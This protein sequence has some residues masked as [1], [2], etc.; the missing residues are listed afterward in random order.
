MLWTSGLRSRISAEGGAGIDAHAVPFRLRT[1]TGPS[2]APISTRPF[3]TAAE[4]AAEAPR[5]ASTSGSAAREQR[6]ERRRVRAPR[7][8]RGRNVM[9][10][11]RELGVLV[12]VEEVVDG[13]IAVAARDERRGRAELDQSL[14]KLPSR[15]SG[16]AGQRLRLGQVRRHD[17]REREEP[18]DQRLDGVVLQQLRARARDQDR[19][20][21]ERDGVPLEELRDRLDDRAREEHPGLRGVDADVV[22]DRVEL[23]ADEVRRQLV[24]GGD[25]RS[26]SAPSARRARSSRMR[27]RRR[28]PSDRP[29]CRRRRPSRTSRSSVRVESIGSLRRHDPDQ[30]RRV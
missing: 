5:A 30:V 12:P 26:C 19:V 13:G 3:R 25:G 22:E 11:D 29:G 8:V 10:L 24:H 23:G 1:S 6:C 28:T 9:A 16:Q 15:R 21:D 17:R 14:G 7:S 2:P 18:L 4:A 20:D 27:P